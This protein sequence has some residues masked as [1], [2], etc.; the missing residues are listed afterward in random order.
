MRVKLLCLGVATL[1]LITS[2][3][4]QA[5]AQGLRGILR[6]GGDF[7]GDPVITFQYADGSK[8]KVESGGGLVASG[9]A[10][11]QLFGSADQALDL[12]ATAGVKYRTIPPASNQTASWIRYP[13]EGLL[14]YRTPFHLRVG[15]GATM[16]LANVLETS[17]SVSNSRYEFKN[18]PGAVF[19]GEYDFGAMALDL[20][21]TMMNYEVAKGGTGTVKA[22]S[23]GLG[24]SLAFGGSSSS[25][26]KAH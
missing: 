8:P 22:N 19:Q 7:G 10:A 14:M 2:I 25:P 17:G 20:R 11:L 21:Y 18:N 1:G 12:Q 15:G 26:A 6:V 13:V 4:P 9:G 23:L 24:F 5:Q 16:H 3:A